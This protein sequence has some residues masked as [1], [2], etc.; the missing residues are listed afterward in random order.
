MMRQRHLSTLVG[1]LLATLLIGPW[2]GPQAALGQVQLAPVAHQQF[3]DANGKPLA[4]GR[5]FT[6]VAGTTTQQATFTDATGLAPNPNP[7]ILDAGGFG[8]IWLS[9]ASYKF[10]VQNA[11]GALQWTVDNITPTSFSNVPNIV[12]ATQP[13][14]QA[15][16]LRLGT[17]DRI[18]WKNVT[19]NGPDECLTENGTGTTA[20]GTIANV[21]S[22]G[23]GA[24]VQA[25]KFFDASGAPAN[26]GGVL[27]TG[28]NVCA[29]AERSADGTTD[30]CVLQMSGS[31][32]VTAVGSSGGISA[33]SGS[34]TGSGG[35]VVSNG[36]TVGGGV[37][38]AGGLSVGSTGITIGGGQAL[39]T[40][41]QT[42]TGSI[43]MGTNP[44]IGGATLTSPKIGSSG[45]I[46]GLQGTDGNLL[47][48]STV[49]TSAGAT[50]CTDAVGGATTTACPFTGIGKILFTSLGGSTC[51]TG[52]SSF[53]QC[54][55]S[56][57]W[58]LPGF[59][60][61]NY[62]AVCMGVSASDPRAYLQ[63]ISQVFGGSVTVVVETLGSQ[64]VSFGDVFCIGIHP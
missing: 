8:N 29:V 40:S 52:A 62:K 61:S 30:V 44:T 16:F 26:G 13:H 4:G 57:N 54:T 43:V 14:A 48:A 23:P 49:A 36:I 20:T 7:V 59:G 63:S 33:V 55:Q 27:N 18:C 34:I 6:Y 45:A 19:S 64:P 35:L 32:N 24:G 41:T 1:S 25:A 21:L 5:V 39:T 42:G 22:Y 37:S 60:D 10:V 11:A 9:T 46:T 17:G 53:A 12:S 3:L 47:T 28:N 58:P 51:T 56:I 15:G 38:V 50:L 2:P 31:A